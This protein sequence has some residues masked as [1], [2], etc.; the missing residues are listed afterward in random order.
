[1]LHLGEIRE[2]FHLSRM[3]EG[4]Q[5]LNPSPFGWL[6]PSGSPLWRNQSL[7]LKARGRVSSKSTHI[8]FLLLLH[9]QRVARMRNW[10]AS[11]VKDWK[12]CQWLMCCLIHLKEF[13][14]AWHHLVFTSTTG[15]RH[16][17][18]WVLWTFQNTDW[19][20]KAAVWKKKNRYNFEVIWQ[21]KTMEF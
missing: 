1:M 12:I 6:D 9:D 3:P 7:T 4:M 17:G 10:V 15:Q 21:M 11:E 20:K 2:A 18:P 5:W 19:K 16:G 14:S 8:F 13:K